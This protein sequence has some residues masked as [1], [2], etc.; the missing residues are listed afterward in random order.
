MKKILV[1]DDEAGLRNMVQ[2]AL[3]QRGYRAIDA[4]DGAAG[5]EVA[6]KQLPDLI[7]CDVNMG[8]MNGYATL[9]A[10]R[11]EPATSTI[12]FILMTGQADN[13]GM[14]HG[15][16]LGADDYL[17]KPFTLDELY[18]SVDA[19]FKKAEAVQAQA[20]RTL[21][22]LRGNIIVALPHQFRTPLNGIIANGEMLATGAS[23]LPPEEIADMGQEIAQSGHALERL[24]ETFLVY[25]QLEVLQTDPKKVSALRGK[26]TAAPRSMIEK[27]AQSKAAEFQRATDL[28]LN[29]SPAA[30]PISEEYF[31][32]LVGELTHNAFK[33]SSA[34]TPVTLELVAASEGVVFSVTDCGRGFAT[35]ELAK[36]GAFMQFDRKTHEQQGL[37]L[38]LTIARQ[39]TEL[40]GGKLAIE[41]ELGRGTKVTVSLPPVQ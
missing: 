8:P 38:G 17:P 10:L 13:E 24:V 35:E 30:V 7:L 33:F 18:K 19:R 4:P 2:M 28:R 20:D 29:I 36:I 15:M 3:E 21:S 1:I 9:S 31:V 32:K 11:N 34:G 16:E 27:E 23:T 26:L 40:H 25:S 39:L 22:S 5:V 37:G 12:P 6:R 41:S 14:R